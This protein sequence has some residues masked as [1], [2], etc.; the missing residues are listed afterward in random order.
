MCGQAVT[1][2]SRQAA[3]KAAS[4]CHHMH[5][6]MYMCACVC[7]CVCVCVCPLDIRCPIS[8]YSHTYLPACSIAI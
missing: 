8:V 1:G 5:V 6:Y 3:T 2:G 4:K 7:V